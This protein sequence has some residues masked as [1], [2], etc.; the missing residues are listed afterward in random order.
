MITKQYYNKHDRQ[1]GNY[2][3]TECHYLDQMIRLGKVSQGLRS[4]W[5]SQIKIWSYGCDALQR[6]VWA[7]HTDLGVLKRKPQAQNG[8]T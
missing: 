3:G 7:R 4:L 5:N 1:L 8:A 6:E 2:G